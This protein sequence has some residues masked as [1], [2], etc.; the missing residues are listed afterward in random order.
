MPSIHAEHVAFSGLAGPKRRAIFWQL[1]W[2]GGCL[3][4]KCTMRLS[5]FAQKP[6]CGLHALPN[7]KFSAACVGR[8]QEGWSEVVDQGS[9]RWGPAYAGFGEFATA[10]CLLQSD[11]ARSIVSTWYLCPQ[12]Q[13]LTIVTRRASSPLYQR[14]LLLS[15]STLC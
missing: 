13:V 2:S 1:W 4:A 10:L 12:G 14:L 7:D 11:K 5:I 15:V 8:G 6:C 9:V 3:A